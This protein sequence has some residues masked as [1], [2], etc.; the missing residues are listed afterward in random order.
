MMKKMT[1]TAKRKTRALAIN[2]FLAV[3]AIAWMGQSLSTD[4]RRSDDR[5]SSLEQFQPSGIEISGIEESH[6]KKR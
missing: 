1:H 5:L 6:T 3:T 2:S 4:N